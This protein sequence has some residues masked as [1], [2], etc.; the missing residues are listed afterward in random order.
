MDRN[1]WSKTKKLPILLK[2]EEQKKWDI[3]KCGKDSEEDKSTEYDADD[4]ISKTNK[5]A[6]LQGA[7][8]QV[9]LL[10]EGK[11]QLNESGNRQVSCM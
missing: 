10:K 4:D 1:K 2:R 3:K 9:Q 6:K 7:A 8:E 5:F 11:P